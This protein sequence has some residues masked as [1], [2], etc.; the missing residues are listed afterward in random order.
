M[1]TVKPLKQGLLYK[2]FEANR[3][4]YLCTAVISFFSFESPPTLLSEPG[5]WKFVSSE[6]G[7]DSMLDMCMPKPRGEVLVTGRCYASKGKASAG[8]VSLKTGPIEKTL[9]VFGNRFWRKTV[10]L[11]GTISDPEPFGEMEI[12]YENAFGGA[13]YKKNPLGKGFGSKVGTTGAKTHPLPNIEDPDELIGSPKDR[14]DLSDAKMIGAN[15]MEA[16]LKSATLVRT[17][18]R[19][20]NLYGAEVMRAVVGDT[21]FRGANLKMTKIFDWRSGDKGRTDK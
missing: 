4:F 16:N 5:F 3:S 17:D 6:I 15:L 11:V 7:K 2:T 9:Y 19:M 10:G 21:D 14:P 12:S 8:E 20:A 18:L 13:E 1:K